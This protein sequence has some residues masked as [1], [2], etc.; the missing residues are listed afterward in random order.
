MHNIVEHTESL[1]VSLEVFCQIHNVKPF[2][3][4]LSQALSASLLAQL[5]RQ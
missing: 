4:H 2:C 1:V 3:Q 5:D